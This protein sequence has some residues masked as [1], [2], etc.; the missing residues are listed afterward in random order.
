MRNSIF[1]LAVAAGL[2]ASLGTALAGDPFA[3]PSAAKSRLAPPKTRP[4]SRTQQ[5]SGY[6]YCRGPGWLAAHVKR[7]AKKA[8]NRARNRSAHR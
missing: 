6:G 1:A 2:S 4:N 3:T 7:M 8:R 5:Y